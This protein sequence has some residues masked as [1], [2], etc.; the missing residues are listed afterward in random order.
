MS[1]VT[2]CVEPGC[3][4]AILDDGYCDT[5]GTK[6]APVAPVATPT[7]VAPAEAAAA[8]RAIGGSISG[9]VAAPAG[10]ASAPGG[11]AG[12]SNGVRTTPTARVAPAVAAPAGLPPGGPGGPGP[13][14][15]RPP[16]ASGRAGFPTPTVEPSRSAG[17]ASPNGARTP[18]ANGSAGGPP[19]G[20]A[21][22]AAA[23]VGASDAS[24]ASGPGSALPK[25]GSVGGRCPEPGC[26]GSILADLYCD[27]CGIKVQDREPMPAISAA[28][29]GFTFASVSTGSALARGSRRTTSTRS[30]R[31]RRL[32]GVG[33]GVIE[34]PT[35]APVDPASVVMVDPQVP[36]HKRFCSSCGAEVGRSRDGEPG[37]LDGFCGRCRH[38][39]DFEP[40]LQPGQLVGGQYEV[41]G[42]LGHGGLGWVYLA[43]DRAVSN[44][45]VVL[46]GL[47]DADDDAAMTAAM[48][49]KQFL[50]EVQHPNIVEIYNFV[51]DGGSSYI[52]MEY[53]GGPT[54]KAMLKART[55]PDGD[56]PPLGPLPVDQA[57]AFIHA[58]LPAF[59]Y[60]HRRG[61][62]YCDFKPDNLCHVGDQVKLIDLGAVRHLNDDTGD[63][64][65]TV[66]Y[67]APE[68]ATLGPSV[69]SDIFTIGRTLAVLTMNFRGYQSTYQ[70]TLPDPEDHPALG[71]WPSFHRLLL[72]A[73]AG[74]PDDRFQSAEE[75][76]EQVLGV[77]RQVASLSSGHPEPGPS[78]HFAGFRNIR[79]LPPL[80][81][82]AS[83][84]AAGFL[85]GL[86]VSDPMAAVEAID[87]AVRGGQVQDSQEVRLR[88]SQA[89]VELDDPRAL[90]AVAQIEADDPWEWR[91]HWLRGLIGLRS[92]DLDAA[93]RS[94]DR[95]RFEVPGELVPEL[96]AAMVAERSKDL[97]TAEALYEIVATVD[98]WFIAADVGLA[99]CRLARGDVA[100]AL[101]AYNQVPA[102]HRAFVETQLGAFDSLVAG[103]HFSEAS[104]L[105]A[106]LD[107]DAARKNRL[108]VALFEAA[109]AARLDDPAAPADEPVPD[110]LQG[111]AGASTQRP[112]DVAGEPFEEKALR[113]GL[114]RACR[115]LA[116][117]T[118]D[119]GERFALVD[120]ANHVRPRSLW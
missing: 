10:G 77:L 26:Q 1:T 71:R 25:V 24:S 79:D 51:A 97:K 52:V 74:H 35:V 21:P 45:W 41:V 67:Q 117:Q 100:G 49:E 50:A 42:L 28:S 58:A 69:A 86:P 104:T 14:T 37:R 22:R 20:P 105:L 48:A 55:E 92:G 114:E 40:K 11:A 96:A 33:A 89:L 65:G 12:G 36:E 30:A 70:Y 75:L 13:S 16:T 99:R 53:V 90:A 91:A 60:L 76:A 32:E 31:G 98:P 62:V 47:L 17:I 93:R 87:D 101:R 27:T 113:R 23:A 88:W 56:Q 111:L 15:P 66:G 95:C 46:K 120:R 82:D 94:F 112:V 39:F 38:R 3:G 54:L 64:Y 110:V 59:D 84:P 57:L 115:R 34:V 73:T 5:C 106:G 102:S 83:D 72:K 63:V 9:A 7:T 18:G 119:D 19:A 68:I 78:S 109:L 61:L 29:A 44:R 107:V 80:A 8:S 85:S 81:V 4:G 103:R 2:A 43:Q 108:E 116:A 118:S 6:A